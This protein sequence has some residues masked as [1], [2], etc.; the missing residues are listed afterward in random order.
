[1]GVQ[2]DQTHPIPAK[3]TLHKALLIRPAEHTQIGRT[4]VM[5]AEQGQNR[6]GQRDK[7]FLQ[8]TIGRLF[9]AIRQI[10]RDHTAGDIP[11][12]LCHS[13]QT[14]GDKR[15]MLPCSVRPGGI[16]QMKIR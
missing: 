6:K 16:H 10:A 8:N 7:L 3:N 15:R 5:V 4:I 2:R 9:A 13:A 1:M 14:A 12:P 11:E